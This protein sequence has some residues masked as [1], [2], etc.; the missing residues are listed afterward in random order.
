MKCANGIKLGNI[1]NIRSEY[2]IA[3]KNDKSDWSKKNEM[4]E[5]KVHSKSDCYKQ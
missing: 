5:F 1:A 2:D 4:E 3:G